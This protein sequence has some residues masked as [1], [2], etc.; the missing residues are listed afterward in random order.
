MKDYWL[1]IL[2][3][4]KTEVD[5][6]CFRTWFS[7]TGLVKVSEDEIIVKVPSRYYKEWITE[8]FSDMLQDIQQ[9]LSIDRFRLKFVV[10]SESDANG[11]IRPEKVP[12]PGDGIL[13]PIGD[14]RLNPKYRF[15][16]F[17]VGPCNQFP[18]AVAMAVVE[19]PFFTYNPVYFYGGVGLGKTHLMHAIGH[20]I[21]HNNP[22]LKL[23]YISSE[24]FMN[25]M[26]NCIRHD[27]ML[28]FREKYRN[29][30]VLLIDDIQFIAGKAQTQM[31]FFHTFNALY[32]NQ[33]QIIISSDC[34]PKDIAKLEERLSSR[35]EWGII[36]DIEP[37]DLETRIAIL[38][39]KAEAENVNFP[40][41]VLYYIADNLRS[42]VRELE[43]SLIRLIAYSSL[44]GES[45]N[46]V[47]AKRV[48]TNIT[49]PEQRVVTVD[50]ILKTVASYFKIKVQDIQSKNNSRSVSHPRHLAMYLT[51]QL[52][53]HSLPKIGE[54]FGG[55]DHTTV[56]HAIR[57]IEQNKEKDMELR[58]VINKLTNLIR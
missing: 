13:A 1:Q 24:R 22:H 54:A 39:K 56:L 18:H 46:L 40:Y 17:V 37:P 48:L 34:H 16:T 32:D 51:R 57:K 35:F 26:I 12:A 9:K 55:K 33:K 19:K 31:E 8:S 28:D 21:L 6:E 36:A 42:N 29:I 3:R 58:T 53:D 38:Q 27:K 52:T 20:T 15:D 41:D 10:D 47:L 2:D 50:R 25:E 49:P 43:G 4:L 30:D 11:Y 7:E 5:E 23:V 45:I 44:T 14:A